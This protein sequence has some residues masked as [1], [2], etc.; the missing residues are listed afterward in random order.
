[1]RRF[2]FDYLR[3]ATELPR[4][5][6]ADLNKT[7]NINNPKR[8]LIINTALIGDIVSSFPAIRQY[9]RAKRPARVDLLVT[10]PLKTLAE[11][12]RG[13]NKVYSARSISNRLIETPTTVAERKELLN[14]HYDMVIALRLSK[15]AYKLLKELKFRAI[16]TTFKSYTRYLA[17]ISGKNSTEDVKQLR[18]FFFEAL[19]GHYEQVG[20]IFDL[21]HEDYRIVR[22]LKAMKG[23][24]QKVIIHTGSGWKL[25]RWENKK[26]IQLLK[27]IRAVGDFTFIFVGG[28]DQEQE[29]FNLIQRN[30]DFKVYSLIKKIDLKALFITMR[31]ADYFIGIDS[32]PRNLSYLADLRSIGLVGPGPRIFMPFSHEDIVINKSDC[33]CSASFCHR[34]PTCM[35]KIQVLDVFSAFVRL[36][37]IKFHALDQKNKPFGRRDPL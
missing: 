2:H 23:A 12:I 24:S 11:R 19:D 33:R 8:I 32:G 9:I 26:W 27:E 5:F 30:L 29:D 3:Q 4:L 6:M 28:D 31:L 37:K 7:K 13:V 25:K 10:S 22:K 34:H 21:C 20:D 1:M 17:Y 18:E 15:E 35:Q 36:A 14:N 16:K